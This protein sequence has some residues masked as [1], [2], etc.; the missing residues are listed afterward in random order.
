MKRRHTSITSNNSSNAKRAGHAERRHAVRLTA[1]GVASIRSLNAKR[2][3]LEKDEI[4]ARM[5]TLQEAFEA[6]TAM[7]AEKKSLP[8][9]FV[10]FN[11]ALALAQQHGIAA[12]FLTASGLNAGTRCSL[13]E[14]KVPSA[15]FVLVRL[16]AGQMDGCDLKVAAQSL[17]EDLD[18]IDIFASDS[19]DDDDDNDNNNNNNNNNN[20]SSSNSSLSLNGMD[21][22]ENNE[23]NDIDDRK[24]LNEIL[25]MLKREATEA[26]HRRKPSFMKSV[27]KM[28]ESERKMREMSSGNGN[29]PDSDHVE[30]VYIGNE[31]DRNSSSN[32]DDNGSQ[33]E[34]EYDDDELLGEEHDDNNNNNNNNDDD[35]V[36][37]QIT[38]FF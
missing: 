33:K 9:G 25:N 18:K 27:F 4:A 37:D 11:T 28:R 26:R 1:Q 20:N 14:G 21:D 8:V 17:L 12:N 29:D 24:M 3:E 19:D 22:E 2:R 5:A 6:K 31:D 10:R 34:E 13:P 7:D 30:W 32:S 35:E 38:Y 15:L 23:S 16:V 36:E